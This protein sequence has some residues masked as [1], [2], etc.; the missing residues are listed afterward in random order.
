MSV[1]PVG[2]RQTEAKM[3]KTHTTLYTS[4]C[5]SHSE[6]KDGTK[7]NTRVTVSKPTRRAR[8]RIKAILGKVCEG[9]SPSET[10][11]CF[12]RAA[13]T[14]TR[15]TYIENRMAGLPRPNI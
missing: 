6:R 11:R 10:R 9:L 12:R 2:R 15:Q 7:E 5:R 3:S 14:T 1:R 8:T 13:A 4:V